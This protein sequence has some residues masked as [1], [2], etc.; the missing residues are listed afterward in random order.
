MIKPLPSGAVCR[1]S[2]GMY[3]PRMRETGKMPSEAELYGGESQGAEKRGTKFSESKNRPTLMV[4]NALENVVEVLEKSKKKGRLGLGLENSGLGEWLESNNWELDYSMSHNG[5][6]M[7]TRQAG[8]TSVKIYVLQRD[9]AKE[10]RMAKMGEE[11]DEQNALNNEMPSDYIE[12]DDIMRRISENMEEDKWLRMFSMFYVV[13]HKA[14]QPKA[15]IFECKSVEA[16][17]FIDHILSADVIE[18]RDYTSTINALHQYKGPESQLLDENYRIALHEYLNTFQ[19]NEELCLV[20]EQVAVG[21]K[22]Y[23][24]EQFK[25]EALKLFKSIKV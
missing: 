24:V 19:V 7:L 16:D 1:L 2:R 6:F 9:L 5:Y 15:S 12:N 10:E 25:A 18:T 14:G 22:H 3:S 23:S 11:T 8:Q 21:L 4:T 13:I 17:M 20:L